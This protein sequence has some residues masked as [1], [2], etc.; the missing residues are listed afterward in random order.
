MLEIAFFASGNK[1]P[2]RHSV[3]FVPNLEKEQAGIQDFFDIILSRAK[4]KE[5]IILYKNK[6]CHFEVS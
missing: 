3:D 2:R 6:E 1:A 5:Y 4:N